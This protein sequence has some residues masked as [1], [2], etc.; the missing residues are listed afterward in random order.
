MTQI[1]LPGFR[2]EPA[3]APAKA[4]LNPDR[5]PASAS[6]PAYVALAHLASMEDVAGRR[7]LATETGGPTETQQSPRSRDNMA[8]IADEPA[9]IDVDRFKRITTATATAPRIVDG[10]DQQRTRMLQGYFGRGS[11]IRTCDLKY[12]KLPR[13][14]AALCPAV[15]KGLQCLSLK[16]GW[17]P[18]PAQGMAQSGVE[19]QVATRE[20]AAEAPQ[21]FCFALGIRMPSARQGAASLQPTVSNTTM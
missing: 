11:R 3:P 15:Q 13:Y 16:A 10:G 12:P 14:R 17:R 19:R 21:P 1:L 9:L 5:H 6:F 2:S 7:T 8:E 4:C 20:V 18:S